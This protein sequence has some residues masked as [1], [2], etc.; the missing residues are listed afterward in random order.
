MACASQPRCYKKSSVGHY[1]ANSSHQ[2]CSSDILHH[3]EEKSRH[4]TQLF[5]GKPTSHALCC[6]FV[7]FCVLFCGS[8]VCLISLNACCH[9]ACILAHPSFRYYLIA[10]TSMKLFC[11]NICPTDEL[12]HPHACWSIHWLFHSCFACTVIHFYYQLVLPCNHLLSFSFSLAS[13]ANLAPCSAFT[14]A[15]LHNLGKEGSPSSPDLHTP[16]QH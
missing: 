9:F 2:P 7:A 15:T 13:R 3:I 4:S 8:I 6:I 5:R 14:K 1:I 16:A 12:P 10:V 11:T